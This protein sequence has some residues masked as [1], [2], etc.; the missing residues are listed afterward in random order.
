MRLCTYKL[1]LIEKFKNGCTL[2]QRRV[3]NGAILGRFLSFPGIEPDLK[4]T[5]HGLFI[6][7]YFIVQIKFGILSPSF[8]NFSALLSHSSLKI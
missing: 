6:I 1:L 8:K 5:P 7:R 4:G 2:F 3:L